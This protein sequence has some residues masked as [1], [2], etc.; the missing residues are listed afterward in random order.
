MQCKDCGHEKGMV[1]NMKKCFKILWTFAL[2]LVLAGSFGEAAAQAREESDTILG[3]VY[4][5]DVDLSGMTVEEATQA[6]SQFVESLKSKNVT[7]GV[8]GERYVAV[9]AGELGL[10]WENTDVLSEAA[11]VGK[12]GNFIKRYMAIQDLKRGNKVYDLELSLDENA[13]K[14][15]LEEQCTEYNIPAKNATMTRVD[16]S[17][18]ISEGQ[19]GEAVNIEESLLKISEYFTDNVWDY[20]DAAIDLVVDVTEP[21]GSAED[22]AKL[23]D[24]LGTFTTS[25]STSSAA[26]CKNVENGCRLINSTILYPGDE[27]STYEAIKPFTEENGYF[28]A[29]SYLNGKVVESLGGGICQVST[30]LYNTVLLSELEVTERNNHSMI[31]TYVEPSMDAA[32]A[33]SS[34]KDF[35]FV[36]N[37]NNP[38]YIEGITEGKQ[39]TFTIYGVEERDPKRKVTYVSETLSVTRPDHEVITAAPGQ[40]IGYISVESAHIGYTAQLWKVVEENGVEV[41]RDVI[42]KSAYK[43]SPRTATV[44]TN[45]DNP[46]YAAR[47]EAAIASGSIDTCKAEAAAINAE[48]AAA[49]QQAADLEAYYQALQQQQQAQLEAQQQAAQ[50]QAT[51]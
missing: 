26:R 23:T 34:G 31:V 18:A 38:I 45:T 30:T 16:G 44:G 29:G 33:E 6:V 39:I 36:N 37:L 10:K 40:G 19:A 2:V 24:V 5:G 42:N 46:A 51:P 4:V 32:I 25:Y 15:I 22:L 47:M 17:F 21:K 48:I 35:K 20:Q 49:Q 9:T 7:L 43:V 13:V 8:A 28:P 12:K 3:G 1:M 50:Q 27:F 41:S 11:S 14:T